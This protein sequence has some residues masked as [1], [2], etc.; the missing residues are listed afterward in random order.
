MKLDKESLKIHNKQSIKYLSLYW[1]DQKLK[2][3]LM[4]TFV[5]T[6]PDRQT[7]RVGQCP[8]VISGGGYEGVHLLAP[9]AHQ[10]QCLLVVGHLADDHLLQGDGGGL[11]SGRNVTRE[12]N[13]VKS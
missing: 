8:A 5:R 12:H 2:K 3:L 1:K 13:C 7:D 4:S 11:Q 10:V 6:F 9:H